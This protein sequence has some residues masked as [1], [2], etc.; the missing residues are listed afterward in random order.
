[1]SL[2]HTNIFRT[3]V[4]LFGSNLETYPHIFV[5]GESLNHEKYM[6]LE[7]YTTMNQMEIIAIKISSRSVLEK[8]PKGQLI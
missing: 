8:Q 5:Y 6:I 3:I 7:Q 4:M 1:M 2:L